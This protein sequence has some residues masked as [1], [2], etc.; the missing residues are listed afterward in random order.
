MK[1]TPGV[2]HGATHE[3][4][5]EP[6]TSRALV[7]PMDTDSWYVGFLPSAPGARFGA[8][9]QESLPRW[10]AQSWLGAWMRLLMDSALVGRWGAASRFG[11][12]RRRSLDREREPDRI[13]QVSRIEEAE[14]DVRCPVTVRADRRGNPAGHYR[15]R[16]PVSTSSILR[17]M[18]EISLRMMPARL[19]PCT[20]SS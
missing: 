9:N 20:R 2:G 6:A 13:G 17:F 16:S 14:V 11:V 4:S 10:F 5:I 19:A 8:P 12:L 1:V 18:M 3:L 15:H 7:R